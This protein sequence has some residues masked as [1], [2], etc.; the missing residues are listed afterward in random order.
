LYLTV[1]DA[2]SLVARGM[3]GRWWSVLPMHVQYFTRPSMRR[4]LEAHGFRVVGIRSHPKV[5][6]WGYYAERLEGYSPAL[7]RVVGG[8]VQ[9]VGLSGRPVAPDF[10]DRMQVLAVRG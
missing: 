2:G 5:L 4:L 1:P 9:R 7:A 3:G 8:A 6:T 10:H